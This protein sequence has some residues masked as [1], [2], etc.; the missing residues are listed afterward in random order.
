LFSRLNVN[1]LTEEN[2]ARPGIVPE[3]FSRSIAVPPHGVNHGSA[4]RA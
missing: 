3:C 1:P 4:A 2:P